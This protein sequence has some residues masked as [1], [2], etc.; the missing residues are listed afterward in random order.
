MITSINLQD[1]INLGIKKE[2]LDE[3]GFKP[4]K[5]GE[6]IAPRKMLNK[7]I[8]ADLI[9]KSKPAPIKAS[10]NLSPTVKTKTN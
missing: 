5:T 8:I 9:E 7:V 2:L 6:S 3:Y 1:L 4:L 10:V